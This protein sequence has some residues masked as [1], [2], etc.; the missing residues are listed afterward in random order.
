MTRQERLHQR[1]SA[2]STF[3]VGLGVVCILNAS[4][5]L[6]VPSIDNRVLWV[7]DGVLKIG[8]GTWMLTLT[9]G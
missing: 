6:L 3:R 4:I 8:F 1:S 7:T 9:Y 2:G 5:G